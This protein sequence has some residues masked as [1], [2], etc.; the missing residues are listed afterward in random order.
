MLLSAGPGTA[1]AWNVRTRNVIRSW[2]CGFALCSAFLPGDKIVVLGTKEGTLEMFDL[3]SS[4][5]VDNVKAHEGHL[6]SCQVS[7]DGKGLVTGS[8]DKTVKFWSIDVVSENVPDSEV[9]PSPTV[10]DTPT[11]TFLNSYKR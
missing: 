8:A 5:I 7:P 6:W 9:P 11:P 2:D 1:K 10:A 3:P 4:T